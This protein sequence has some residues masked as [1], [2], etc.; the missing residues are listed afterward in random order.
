VNEVFDATFIHMKPS[1]GSIGVLGS[2]FN[3]TGSRVYGLI[4]NESFPSSIPL[5]SLNRVAVYQ[6]VAGSFK[7]WIDRLFLRGK[8]LN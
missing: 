7:L 2:P 3:E 8:Y 4:L 6:S 1:I 5:L